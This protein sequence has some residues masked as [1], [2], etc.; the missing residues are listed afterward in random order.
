MRL[1]SINMFRKAGYT[2]MNK[3]V[4]L[5]RSQWL[6]CPLAICVFVLDGNLFKCC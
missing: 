1:N 5:S 4:G 3:N 2:Q 6:P